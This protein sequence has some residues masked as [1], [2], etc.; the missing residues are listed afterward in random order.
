MHFTEATPPS[1]LGF[2]LVLAAVVVSAVAAVHHSTRSEAGAAAARA[3]SWRFAAG[4]ALWLGGFT[5]LVQS[6]LPREKPLPFVPLIFVLSNVAPVVLAFSPLGA[7]LSAGLSLRTLV[8]FQAFRLPLELVLHAWSGSRTIPESMTWTGSNL[9]VVTGIVALLLA[10][11]A[12]RRWA[13]W[14]VNLV[15]SVLL[16]NVARVAVLSSPLPFG[17]DVEPRLLLAA[18]WPYVY[19]LP[20]C[21]AGAFAGH[22]LLTRKLLASR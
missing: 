15:G 13:A 12:H 6:G 14:A 18:Y 17:W 1:L 3:A 4:L 19:I 9:D 5:A 20:V 2:W 22:L 10:P 16:L 7:R 11:L 21:V 8:L